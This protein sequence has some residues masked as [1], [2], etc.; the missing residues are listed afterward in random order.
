[1]NLQILRDKFN[2][3]LSKEIYLKQQDLYF[4]SD[5]CFSTTQPVDACSL[6][7]TQSAGITRGQAASPED[8]D[9][10]RFKMSDPVSPINWSPVILFDPLSYS[11]T[12]INTRSVL[13][14]PSS[15][16]S[17]LK[18]CNLKGNHLT[19]FHTLRNT[20]L[21][22]QSLLTCKPA[23]YDLSYEYFNWQGDQSCIQYDST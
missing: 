2:Y 19:S 22:S 10:R 16:L 15:L 21:I 23:I 3:S 20:S 17:E 5:P 8:M 4:A 14:Y 11:N 1:M 13:V 12:V 18:I 6:D 7:R 9:R